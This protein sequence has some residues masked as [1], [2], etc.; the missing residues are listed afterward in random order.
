MSATRHAAGQGPGV[1]P[2]PLPT[3]TTPAHIFTSD[4]ARWRRLRNEF[5]NSVETS[6]PG[7]LHTT[8]SAATPMSSPLRPQLKLQWESVL[9]S[10]LSEIL[11][12]P[13]EEEGWWWFFLLPKF[14]LHASHTG[15]LSLSEPLRRL[16]QG[17]FHSL[18]DDWLRL[19][20]SRSDVSRSQNSRTARSH[21]QRRAQSLAHNGRLRD[22]LAALYSSDPRIETSTR[23]PEVEALFPEARHLTLS[24]RLQNTIETW[25]QPTYPTP[26]LPQ[27]TGEALRSMIHALPRGKCPGLS[28]LRSDHL[29]RLKDKPYTNLARMLNLVVNATDLLPWPAGY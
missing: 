21:R 18:W 4:P 27:L 2:G 8:A 7:G 14:V 11:E 29:T 5:L 28:G 3:P 15:G 19:L 24:Y 22:S 20:Q 13:A 23:W 6:T 9:L 26:A 10:A 25:P 12:S 17:D 16:L 1:F